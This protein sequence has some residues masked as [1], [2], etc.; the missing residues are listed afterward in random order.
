MLTLAEELRYGDDHALASKL[1]AVLEELPSPV[2]CLEPLLGALEAVP[3]ERWATCDPDRLTLALRRRLLD[4]PG[5]LPLIHRCEQ[6]LLSRT[7]GASHVQREHAS[8]L[9]VE[10]F[11]Q[12]ARHAGGVEDLRWALLANP[13]EELGTI[14][15]Q[16]LKSAAAARWQQPSLLMSRGM[17]GEF[18][19]L[20]VRS[21]KDDEERVFPIRL[22]GDKAHFVALHVQRAREHGRDYLV[23]SVLDPD[24]IDQPRFFKV[25]MDREKRWAALDL[26]ALLARGDRYFDT[27]AVLGVDWALASQCTRGLIA[28]TDWSDSMIVAVQSGNATHLRALHKALPWGWAREWHDDRALGTAIQRALLQGSAEPMAALGKLLKK[29]GIEPQRLQRMLQTEWLPDSCL[30]AAMAYGHWATID[31]FGGLLQLAG[32]SAEQCVRILE[33]RYQGETGL[34]WALRRGNHAA[35]KAF[36]ALIKGA[37]RS[38]PGLFGLL[39]AKG[40]DWIEDRG[41]A[42]GELDTGWK[43]ALFEGHARAIRAFAHILLRSPLSTVE[44]NTIIHDVGAVHVA[45]DQPLLITQGAVDLRH[46]YGHAPAIDFFEEVWAEFHPPNLQDLFEAETD[47]EA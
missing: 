47:D 7:S 1:L 43:A 31:A 15:I 10:A 6:L 40:S 41:R 45:A 42:H 28:P 13:E 26:N 12:R 4:V 46:A 34:Y 8:P 17:L 30:A 25:P 2:Q 23:V 16:T 9:I 33:G 39:R 35:I 36:G 37:D 3:P 5:Q 38:T 11:V 29:S 24:R 44:L 27:V 19:R 20:W 22:A 18:L 14:G 32:A 21:M